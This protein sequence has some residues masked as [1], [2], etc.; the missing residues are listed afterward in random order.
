[1]RQVGDLPGDFDPARQLLHERQ[2]LH[3]LLVGELVAQQPRQGAQELVRVNQ[4]VPSARVS[5]G[6]AEDL[7][8][9]PR[10]RAARLRAREQL[11][12][13]D[14]EFRDY[15][16][17]RVEHAQVYRHAQRLKAGRFARSLRLFWETYLQ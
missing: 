13:A 1:M 6:V 10:R 12:Q 17:R 14:E 11:V 4:H 7:D 3:L 16:G 9:V 2:Q 5:A 15:A 8:A